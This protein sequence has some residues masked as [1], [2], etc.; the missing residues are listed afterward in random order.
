MG[1]SV[2]RA[3]A[4]TSQYTRGDYIPG[5]SVDGMDILAVREASRF[6]VDHIVQG[7]GPILM[8]ASTYR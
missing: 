2:D 6:A 1:T 5:I 7:K 8:E 4:N 3:A